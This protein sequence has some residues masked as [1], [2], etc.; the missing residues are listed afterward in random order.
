MR[1]WGFTFN[2]YFVF[3]ST[4]YALA[5]LF[6]FY[7]ITLLKGSIFHIFFNCPK[8]HTLKDF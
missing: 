8:L 6:L 4:F 5:F 3:S 7:V 2:N 1:A